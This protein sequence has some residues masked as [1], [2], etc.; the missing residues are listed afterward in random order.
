MIT[1]LKITQ[2]RIKFTL[3]TTLLY[4]L[5]SMPATALNLVQPDRKFIVE[6][7]GNLVLENLGLKDRL[8]PLAPLHIV[9]ANNRYFYTLPDVPAPF[10]YSMYILEHM[11]I[12][13]GEEVLDIG[14]GSGILSIFAADTAKRVV[15]SDLSYS[16]RE[17]TRMNALLHEVDHII[18]ARQG[19]LFSSISSDELFDVIILSIDFPRVDS[20]L[21]LWEVHS[22]FLKDVGQYLKENGRIYYV[23]GYYENLPKLIP[24]ISDNGFKIMNINNY[25]S[26]RYDIEPMLLTL[27]KKKASQ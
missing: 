4:G 22:R 15:A 26:T 6:Y 5:L 27:E 8:P 2:S 20:W 24:M 3:V 19:D 16:A 23:F 12:L 17:N 7:S 18:D 11:K 21:G 9:R 25:K 14:S 13:P 10:V 1:C